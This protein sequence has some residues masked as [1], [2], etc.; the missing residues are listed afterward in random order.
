MK[1]TFI[2]LIAF[3]AVSTVA[4][5]SAK[6]DSIQYLD[7]RFGQNWF[8]SVDGSINWW[9]GSDENPNGNY[10]DVQWGRPSY[11]GGLS[12]GRWVN[13][14]F[15]IKFC[16]DVN[17]GKSYI[18]GLH[19]NLRKLNFL[20][21]G[22]FTYDD[23]GNFV[24][25]DNGSDPD[26][27]GYYNTSFIYH[28]LHADFFV[29]PVDI[30]QGY[31]NPNIVYRPVFYVGMGLASVSEGI[32]M[33]PTIINNIKNKNNEDAK[34]GA[35]Y[36]FSFNFGMLNSFRLTS[37]L[38]F[39][40]DL[41]CSLQRWNIDS[42]F[43]EYTGETNA[44]QPIRSLRMDKNFSAK[45]GLTF[46]INKG[47][48][49]PNNCAEE[50]EEMRQRIKN[51]EDDMANMSVEG[52]ETPEVTV[53]HDTITQFVNTHTED[54]I[55]YPFSIFFERDSYQ[56]MSKR[57]LVNLRELAE[58]AKK[59]GYKIRLRGSADSATATPE[60]NQT[61]SENRCR[62]V[63]IELMDMGIPESQIILLPVGG[64]NELNPELDRR[65]LVELIKEA[66]KH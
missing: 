16:Y 39:F 64:V 12:V 57:D 8:I 26:A 3:M 20:F 54:I 19:V 31:Y 10:T 25:Y 15:G 55:S 66:P 61:L 2:T 34:K 13:H 28:N 1:K 47:Y 62:K 46:N 17:Q 48:S 7:A 9:Q 65:V 45:A 50:M 6:T 56:L 59:N 53:I 29:S 42:W 43:Y 51:L 37:F 58:V 30:I 18:D 44:S 63:M 23:N 49:L 32:L 52:S 27:N 24:S 41:D 38:D 22:D 35:N 33:T 21:D 11:G 36:E 60:H 14:N 40:I 4:M 5:A